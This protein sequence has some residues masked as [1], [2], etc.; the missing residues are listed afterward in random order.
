MRDDLGDRMKRYEAVTRFVLPP[1]TYT[2]IRVDG[3]NFHSFTRNFD[4]PFDPGLMNAMQDV[5]D[6]DERNFRITLRIHSVG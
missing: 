1:R 6:D 5:A 3:K 2:I 4:K